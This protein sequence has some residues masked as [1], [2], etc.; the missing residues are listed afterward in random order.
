MFKQLIKAISEIYRFII[1]LIV[2]VILGGATY[3]C[4]ML[5]DDML[6]QKQFATEGQLITVPVKDIDLKQRSWRDIIGNMEYLTV[7]YQGK[8][9]SVRYV[10]DSSFVSSGDQI[11]LLYLPEKDAFRQP[12]NIDHFRQTTNKSRLVQWTTVRDFT[13]EHKMLLMC[14]V[15]STASF[16]FIAG[17]IATYIPVPLLQDL[18]RILL[19]IEFIVGTIFLTYDSWAYY[20]YY[21]RLKTKGQEISVKVLDTNR[22]VFGRSSRNHWYTYEATVRYQQ[23]RIIRIS[24]DDYDRLKPGSSLNVVYDSSVDDM[25]SVNYPAGFSQAILPVFFGF[26][27]VIAIRSGFSRIKRKEQR[28]Y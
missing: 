3:V 11:K 2:I 27:T 28:V 5:Y 25:M 26:L 16:F 24:E 9:Y 23:E 20:Q 15:L 8:D 19:T 21:N 10:R 17:F 22:R 14:L 4:W 7:D 12:D 18:A 6:L 13:I 1:S